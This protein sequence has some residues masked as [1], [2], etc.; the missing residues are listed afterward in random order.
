M[1][2]EREFRVMF[3]PSGKAGSDNAESLVRYS[4]KAMDV[5]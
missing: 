1:V 5:H 2:S 3:V 4:G